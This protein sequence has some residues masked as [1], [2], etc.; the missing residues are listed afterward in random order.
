[1]KF[2]SIDQPWNDIT[3]TLNKTNTKVLCAIGY[4]GRDAPSI[5]R[6]GTGDVLVCDA[7][8]ITVKSGS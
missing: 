8:D 3:E 4:I 1:M 2:L 5:L 6:L 7:S